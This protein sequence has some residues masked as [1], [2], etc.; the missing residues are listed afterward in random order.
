M[1]LSQ[2]REMEDGHKE[3]CLAETG[4]FQEKRENLVTESRTYMEEY[5]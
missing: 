4:L 1:T 2:G 5:V 3:G